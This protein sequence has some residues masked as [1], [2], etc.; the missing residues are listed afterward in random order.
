MSAQFLDYAQ[1]LPALKELYQGQKVI[2]LVYKQNPFLALLKKDETF[3][4]KYLPIPVLY[5]AGGG[6]SSNFSNAQG[7]QAPGVMAEFLITTAQ[8][9]GIATITRQMKLQ[10]RSNAGAFIKSAEYL[11]DN[12]YKTVTNRIA[13]Q[14]FRSGSGTI[15]QIGSIST[16]GSGPYTS[17]ITLADPNSSVQFEVGQT[18]VASATDGGSA[19][20]D[21]LQVTKVDRSG[22][23]LVATSAASP[24]GTWTTNAYLSTQGDT[25]S[26]MKGLAAWLPTSAPTAGDNFFGVDR[27]AD[28]TRLAGVRVSLPN[29]LI[30]E[31]LIQAANQV[32]LNDGSPDICIMSVAGF[33]ALEQSLGSKVVI[34]MEEAAGVAFKGIHINGPAGVIRVFADRNCPA[35]TAYMLE[36]SSW[37]LTS[38]LAAPH[39]QDDDGQTMLRVANADASEIRVSAYSQLYCNAP[40]HN[41][42][43]TI[44]A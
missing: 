26:T 15:G 38:M 36:S 27:S 17:T 20:S 24:S 40:G 16:S 21:S 23:T 37:C 33:T 13:S 34:N 30:E 28:P 42:V 2:D 10:G 22:G 39:L 29:A 3:E 5:G 41:A 11:V 44:S 35:K 31:A 1:M 12:A 6:G 7:N 25:N 32:Y 18:L 19:S 43:V 14:L 9:Y 8:N 4:G